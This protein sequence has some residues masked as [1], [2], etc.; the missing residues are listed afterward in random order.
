MH[1]YER[2]F[3]CQLSYNIVSRWTLLLC[4]TVN[5]VGRS[6]CCYSWIALSAFAFLW[7]PTYTLC[8]I[9]SDYSNLVLY[10]DSLKLSHIHTLDTPANTEKKWTKETT[11]HTHN[12]FAM[13]RRIWR[14]HSLTCDM[15]HVRTK[16]YAPSKR[17]NKNQKK[18][19]CEKVKFAR[20]TNSRWDM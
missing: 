16:A 7:M 13:G 10:F 9:D 19:T 2:I 6:F 14:H 3:V 5:F 4:T 1:A 8:P 20:N 11:S 18:K 17:I 15:P 12:G